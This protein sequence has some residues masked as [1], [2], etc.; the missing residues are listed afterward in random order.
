MLRRRETSV[1]A[2]KRLMHRSKQRIW[3]AEFVTGLFGAGA[4]RFLPSLGRAEL[5]GL[6]IL[7]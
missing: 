4:C 3:V 1:S 7:L 5:A 2:S 6:M